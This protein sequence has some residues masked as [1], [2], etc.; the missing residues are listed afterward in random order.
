VGGNIGLDFIGLGESGIL[1]GKPESLNIPVGVER[2]LSVIKKAYS[3]MIG[4]K[5]MRLAL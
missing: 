3:L 4:S 5:F 2:Q 1:S